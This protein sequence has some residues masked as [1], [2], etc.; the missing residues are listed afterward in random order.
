[1]TLNG[2]PTWLTVCP[3][4]PNLPLPP[5]PVHCKQQKNAKSMDQILSKLKNM[6]TWSRASINLIKSSSS[7]SGGFVELGPG[8]GE[9]LRGLSIL[10]RGA[11]RSTKIKTRSNGP[12]IMDILESEMGMANHTINEAKLAKLHSILNVLRDDGD[13]RKCDSDAPSEPQVPAQT[14]N[15][16]TA[17]TTTPEFVSIFDNPKEP[18]RD[19]NDHNKKPK[20]GKNNLSK[21]AIQLGDF[22]DVS[23]D[24]GDNLDGS[25]NLFRHSMNEQSLAWLSSNNSKKKKNRSKKQSRKDLKQERPRSDSFQKIPRLRESLHGGR[26]NRVSK[27]TFD[28]ENQLSDK[29]RSPSDQEGGSRVSKEDGLKFHYKVDTKQGI[30][31]EETSLTNITSPECK[32]YPVPVEISVHRISVV[33]VDKARDNENDR[34]RAHSFDTRMRNQAVPEESELCVKEEEDSYKTR[35]MS[36]GDVKHLESANDEVLIV[37]APLSST[38]TMSS[39]AT[40][41]TT[42][43]STITKQLQQQPP[44][45]ENSEQKEH[46][47]NRSSIAANPNQKQ[48][49]LEND[50][51]V[52]S[53]DFKMIRNDL[54]NRS[55]VESNAG[56]SESWEIIREISNQKRKSK[57]ISQDDMMGSWESVNEGVSPHSDLSKPKYRSMDNLLDDST[58]SSKSK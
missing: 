19:H 29:Q 47:R 45:P 46:D 7:G 56:L 40:S 55:S 5:D 13:E 58:E 25:G 44:P 6:K 34:I 12:K 16:A 54:K 39:T 48:V 32:C 11:K 23:S 9:S 31:D 26:V 24:S 10:N 42:T 22:P 35:S 52:S 8:A 3:L 51:S 18:Q 50:E 15:K 43:N 37:R 20:I 57:R 38:T 33:D 30:K 21:Y 41:T 1:M 36:L 49:S 4:D 28:D 27:Y 2:Q 53:L 17:Q 14:T